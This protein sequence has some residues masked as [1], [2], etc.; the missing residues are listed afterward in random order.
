MVRL[1]IFFTVVIVLAVVSLLR[2]V[3]SS[4]LMRP[5]PA[6]GRPYTKP[7]STKQ[8]A[9]VEQRIA[10]EDKSVAL[11]YVLWFFLGTVGI[12]NFYI[13]RSDRGLVELILC[14]VGSIFLGVGYSFPAHSNSLVTLMA[15]GI[16]C[17]FVWTLFWLIDLFIIPSM[18]KKYRDNLR[19]KY[20]AEFASG[21]PETGNI[22]SSNKHTLGTTPIEMGKL[23]PSHSKSCEPH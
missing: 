1:F 17:L 13:G 3:G 20:I 8:L 22:K 12:H 7:V 23:A 21:G 6:M 4:K 2:I 18:I 5:N 19:T 11:A 10:N 15:F 9:V 16:A 14:F